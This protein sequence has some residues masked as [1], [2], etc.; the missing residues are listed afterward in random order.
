MNLVRSELETSERSFRHLH[1]PPQGA[2]FE[3]NDNPAPTGPGREA[4][5]SADDSPLENTEKMKKH[6]GRRLPPA[7]FFPGPSLGSRHTAAREVARRWSAG[8]ADF[9]LKKTVR[10]SGSR[11]SNRWDKAA[12]FYPCRCGI[13]IFMIGSGARGTAKEKGHETAHPLSWP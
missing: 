7:F 3:N 9:L 12:R 6:M 11:G 5:C 13:K 1:S 4:H 2:T 8:R 10:R